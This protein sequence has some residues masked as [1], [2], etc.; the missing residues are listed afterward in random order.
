MFAQALDE[1]LAQ[2]D[3][4]LR[5]VIWG[6]DEQALNRTKFTQ[7]AL[8][9][10][11]VALYRLA[12]SLGVRPDFVAG[13]SVGEIA[14]AHVAGVLSLT[15]ACTLVS[16]RARLMQALPE[17]GLMLAIE[18]TEDEVTPYLTDQVSIAAINSPTSLV[19][20]GTED[21]V[22]AAA[23]PDRRTTRLRVSHAFHSLLMDPMLEDFRAAIA[24]LRFGEPNIPFVSGTSPN[25]P[26]YWVQ[27]VRDTVRFADNIRTLTDHGVTRF[28]EIGPDGTLTPSSHRPPTR[29]PSSSRHFARPSQKG[30]PFLRL[31]AACSHTV[32]PSTGRL[33]SPGQNP[34]SPRSSPPTPSS[35][36]ASGRSPPCR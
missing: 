31:W 27:H 3:P 17:G 21:A 13:H 10:I 34:D 4:A 28:L 33:S 25:T 32:C 2:L 9:A 11:E 16:A 35:G 22:L 5:E 29:T 36:A 19:L 20:S 18:A 7:P 14:A 30:K 6:D 8:F 26:G 23:L 24:D 15:D 12:E 1:A